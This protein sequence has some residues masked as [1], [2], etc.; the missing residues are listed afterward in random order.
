MFGSKL[1]FAET[2]FHRIFFLHR[3]KPTFEEFFLAKVESN[4]LNIFLI[5][6][7]AWRKKIDFEGQWKLKIEKMV[8]PKTR[9]NVMSVELSD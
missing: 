5:K 7:S 3:T 1:I 4:G 9:R 6:A 8:K 2:N